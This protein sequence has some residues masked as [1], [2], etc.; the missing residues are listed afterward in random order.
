MKKNDFGFYIL[1]E[2][3]AGRF[4]TIPTRNPEAMKWHYERQLNF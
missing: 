4:N 3:A 2:H 1:D